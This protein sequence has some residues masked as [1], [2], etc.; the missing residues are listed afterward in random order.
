MS[1]SILDVA[2]NYKGLDHQIFALKML[3]AEISKRY[4]EVTKDSALWVQK[5]RSQAILSLLLNVPFYPQTDNFTQPDRTCN[6]SACA[7]AAKFLGAKI[8][9]D[10]QY[11]RKVLEIGDT[12]DHGVQTSALEYFGIKSSWHTDLDFADLDRQL[13]KEKPV[14]IGILHR[15]TNPNPTGG[16]MIVGI[17]KK[18][19]GYVF[20]DPYGSLLDGYSS[21]VA[22]GKNV[23]Y[24]KSV[25]ENRWLVEGQKSGWGRVFN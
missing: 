14:V 13:T 8:S 17:G 12:T 16:H 18:Q 23:I 20:H 4:P 21:D 6:S 25:L 5:W 19:D 9:G 11:L 3:D 2:R 15:G 1:I 7:M 22:S 10:D 24:S